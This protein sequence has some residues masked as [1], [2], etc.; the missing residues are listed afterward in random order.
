MRPA[1]VSGAIPPP[2]GKRRL[3]VSERRPSMAEGTIMALALLAA[4]LLIARLT[5]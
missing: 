1:W 5:K 4:I 2:S 3:A